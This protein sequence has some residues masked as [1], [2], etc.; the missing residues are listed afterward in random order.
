MSSL[1]KVSDLSNVELSIYVSEIDL[2]KVK[3]GQK[4]E[5]TVDAFE[6]KTFEGVIK[7]ILPEAEF[8]PKNIQTKDERTITCIPG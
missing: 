5:I 2:G 8:T 7:Y 6:N 3:L 4:A 1:V